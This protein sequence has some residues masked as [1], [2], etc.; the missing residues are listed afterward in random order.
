MLP[1]RSPRRHRLGQGRMV[2]YP[3]SHRLLIQ[4]EQPLPTSL[5]TRLHSPPAIISSPS[6]GPR[7]NDMPTLLLSH[8]RSSDHLRGSDRTSAPL[9]PAHPCRPHTQPRHLG[10]LPGAPGPPPDI[11]SPSTRGTSSGLLA[12]RRCDSL[13]RRHAGPALLPVLG[14]LRVRTGRAPPPQPCLPESLLE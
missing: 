9:R 2:K 12:S 4:T 11:S 3:A 10:P 5:P 13:R 14:C 1:Q 7:T 8:T 6:L